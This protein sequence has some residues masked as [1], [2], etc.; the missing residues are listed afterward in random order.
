[1]DDKSNNQPITDEDLK[2]AAA[3]VGQ[4]LAV[5]IT[6]LNISP[7]AKT[8]LAGVVT[9]MNE[10]Q[11]LELTNVLE[12]L[13]AHEATKDLDEKL[14][15]QVKDIQEKYAA[16]VKKGNDDAMSAILEIE[17]QLPQE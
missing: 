12:N 17:K 15:Q 9:L 5:L 10:K 6:S 8:N 1:M 2:Q 14:E 7:E 16:K 3:L 11:I 4:K 13:M